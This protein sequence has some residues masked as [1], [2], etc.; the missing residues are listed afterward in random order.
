[1]KNVKYIKFA[2]T[3]FY[4]IV[5]YWVTCLIFETFFNIFRISYY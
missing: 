2:I 1:M 5:S 3:A 4:L